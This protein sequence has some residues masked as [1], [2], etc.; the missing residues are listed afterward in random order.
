MQV[1]KMIEKKSAGPQERYSQKAKEVNKT[2]ISEL[3]EATVYSA[4][5]VPQYMMALIPSELR[6]REI[7]TRVDLIK[8]IIYHTTN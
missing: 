8:K 6:E 5:K 1:L 3:M 2:H 7:K 4:E